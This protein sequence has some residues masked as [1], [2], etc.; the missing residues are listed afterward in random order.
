[1]RALPRTLNSGDG[2]CGCATECTELQLPAA[3][4]P[5]SRHS[6]KFSD[7]ILFIIYSNDLDS[8]VNNDVSRFADDAKSDNMVR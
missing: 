5:G 1:M 2:W 6:D 4:I 7:P 8:D 3:A